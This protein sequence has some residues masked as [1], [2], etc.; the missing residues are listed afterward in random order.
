LGL[1]GGFLF[2][3]LSVTFF[4][5]EKIIAWG[6]ISKLNSFLNFFAFILPNQM[7]TLIYI[8]VSR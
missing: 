2:A 3:Y 1:L 7:Q 5:C 6:K 8:F 4:A